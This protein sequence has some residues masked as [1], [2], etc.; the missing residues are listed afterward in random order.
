MVLVI[1]AVSLGFVALSFS[2]YFHRT[3]AQRAA[4]VFARDLT[5]ARSTAMR[6]QE[7]V[8]IGFNEDSLYYFV[9]T[10]ESGTELARRRFGTNADVALSFIDLDM[11]SDTLN[12]SPRGV[13]DLGRATLGAAI[14]TSGTA[15]YQVSF[16]SLGASK[17]EEM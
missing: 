10:L 11:S 4:R 3:S 16:N 14:F 6:T 9:E 13:V 7:N 17:V 1:S 5:F 8:I 12:F 2:G 15:S